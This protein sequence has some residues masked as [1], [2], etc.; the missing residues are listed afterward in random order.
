MK[1]TLNLSSGP[2]LSDSNLNWKASGWATSGWVCDVAHSPRSPEDNLPA[3]QCKEY[4]EGKASHF[5]EADP[6]CNFIREN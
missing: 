5:V 3:N 2:C 6:S 1:S 4:I